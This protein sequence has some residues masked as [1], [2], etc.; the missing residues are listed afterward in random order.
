M[1]NSQNEFISRLKVLIH[2]HADDSEFSV[3]TICTALG[4]SRSQLHRI[5]KDQSDLSVTLYIRKVR[6][7]KARYLLAHTGLRISEVAD[8]VGIS[9]PQNFSKYF[10]AEFSISPTEYRRLHQATRLTTVTP[11]VPDD[12]KEPVSLPSLSGTARAHASRSDIRTAVLRPTLN[13][14]LLSGML[15]LGLLLGVSIYFYT[16]PATRPADT[17]VTSLAVLPLTNMGTPDMDPVCEGLMDDIHTGVS[18]IRHLRVTARASSDRY[19]TRQKNIEQIGEDLRVVNIL[20]GKLLK[21]GDQIQVKIELINARE[22]QLIWS[23]IYRIAYRDV[24][25]LTEQISQDVARE[26]GLEK[27]PTVTEKLALARTQ[28]VVAYNDFLQGRQLV[29]SR[30]KDKVLEGIAKFDQALAL[31]STFAEAHAFKGLAYSVLANLDYAADPANAYQQAQQHALK[32]IQV[33]A[34]NSTAYG[35]LGTIYADT[36]QWQAAEASFRMALQ[37]NANDAQINYWYSLLLRSTGGLKEAIR[38]S[39]QAVALDPLYPVILSGHITN[40]AYAN[41]FDLA[42]ASLN[43]GRALFGDQFIYYMGQ[44]YF[45][46]AK[47]NYKAASAC[48]AHG[49]AINPQYTGIIPTLMYCEA[50]GGNRAKAL[51][52]LPSL[53]TATARTYYDKAVVFAG[54]AQK[55][56][57]LHY[58]KAAADGGYMYKDIKVSPLFRAYHTEPVFQAIL[59]QYRLPA[60]P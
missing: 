28:N 54:L 1:V 58:L 24:F 13:Y 4:I 46:L 31:D 51:A 29:I 48:F 45:Y 14:W 52:Y 12:G 42:H 33:D 38:Y 18:L 27:N 60:N 53:T 57:C 55:D 34:T 2:E 32:A 20:R 26:L 17:L 8:R 39:A 43:S 15:L 41:R 44:G 35:V 11:V 9:N 37:H 6:L 5:V 49:L 21:T 10:V 22:G 30:K 40:C 47:N 56:S 36:Y 19:R 23:K 16:Q 59:R 50:K 25:Q 3:D 7:E